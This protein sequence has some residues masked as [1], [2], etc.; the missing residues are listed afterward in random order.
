MNAGK[1]VASRAK[2]KSPKYG[3]VRLLQGISVNKP[4][5]IYYNHVLPIAIDLMYHEG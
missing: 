4:L 3:F 5:G 1:E 2:W